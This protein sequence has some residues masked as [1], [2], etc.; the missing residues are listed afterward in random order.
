MEDWESFEDPREG[1]MIADVKG[2]SESDLLTGANLQTPD[3]GKGLAVVKDV[4]NWTQGS[5][6]H[7]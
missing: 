2:E 7:N 3:M 5:N 4:E 1:P 6:Y